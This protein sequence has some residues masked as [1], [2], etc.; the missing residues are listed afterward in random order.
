MALRLNSGLR[1]LLASVAA[2]EEL[3]SSSTSLGND[4]KFACFGGI[5]VPDRGD[6]PCWV[7]P[8]PSLWGNRPVQY[9]L[10]AEVFL[11]QD[12]SPCKQ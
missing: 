7:S 12:T 4:F 5:K 2:T 10:T 11:L 3:P 6:F 1:R 9:D 8:K